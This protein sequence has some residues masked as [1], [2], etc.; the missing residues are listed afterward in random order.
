[1]VL[2]ASGGEVAVVYARSGCCSGH[3]GVCGPEPQQVGS[4]VCYKYCDG[5]RL[6]S[7]CQPYY[8]ECAMA[9]NGHDRAHLLPFENGSKWDDRHI[10]N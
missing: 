4:E 8:P 1:M 10:L 3:S 7:V 5:V 2:V 9:T 6:S